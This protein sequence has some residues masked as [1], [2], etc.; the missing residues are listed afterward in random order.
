MDNGYNH[1]IFKQHKIPVNF[2][3]LLKVQKLFGNLL[4]VS[5]VIYGKKNFYKILT[6]KLFEDFDEFIQIFRIK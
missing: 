4:L 2:F 3:F 1:I 5:N 6:D